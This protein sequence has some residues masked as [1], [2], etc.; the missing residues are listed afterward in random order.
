MVGT[1]LVH[2]VLVAVMIRRLAGKAITWWLVSVVEVAA[3]MLY[4]PYGDGDDW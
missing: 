1:M 2:V 3:W 4:L